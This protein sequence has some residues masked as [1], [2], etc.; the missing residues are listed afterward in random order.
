[1][2]T[3]AHPV[4]CSTIWDTTLVS[5][6]SPEA[7]PACL[8]LSTSYNVPN[9][10]IR[11]NSNGTWTL[12][13]NLSAFQQSHPVAHLEADDFEPDGTWYSMVAVRG[14]L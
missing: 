1:M 8:R 12:I 4:A 3:P 2:Q 10:I 9:G 7:S 6:R 14:D 5:I 13:A 11:V